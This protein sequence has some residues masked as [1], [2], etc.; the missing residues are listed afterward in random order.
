[1]LSPSAAIAYHL[2]VGNKPID[3]PIIIAEIL[4]F[5]FMFWTLMSYLALAAQKFTTKIGF[6]KTSFYIVS[7]VLNMAV[8]LFFI[9]AV[10][11]NLYGAI[12]YETRL[13]YRGIATALGAIAGASLILGLLSSRTLPPP[14]SSPILLTGLKNF[15]EYTNGGL[16]FPSLTLIKGDVGTG[17]TTVANTITVTRLL[18]N[19][20]VIRLC[21]DYPPAY[22]RLGLAGLGIDPKKY[23]DENKLIL[24]DVFTVLSGERPSEKYHS[25]REL[26]DVLI[27]VTNL[28]KSLREERTWIVIDS[29][30]QILEESG[31]DRFL[32]FMRILSA[33]CAVVG[34]GLIATFNPSSTTPMVTALLEEIFHTVLELRA[35]DDTRQ[36]RIVKIPY[37]KTDGRWMKIT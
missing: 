3:S 32:K 31:H 17:K 35:R 19:E 28:T 5:G 24:L 36:I 14:E 2:T 6:E 11:G 37:K 18:N 26:N 9:Y 12:T 1:L 33:K 34:A 8:A 25:S 13:I 4:Y 30:D 27:T 20:V 15:D 23:E 29:I 16:I 7:S 22:V 21:F 10:S